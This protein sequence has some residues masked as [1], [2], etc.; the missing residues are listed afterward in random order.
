MGV[1]S[2]AAESDGVKV[3][4]D[5]SANT[6]TRHNLVPTVARGLWARTR[7]NGSPRGSGDPRHVQ[8][9]HQEEAH[10]W[11]FTEGKAP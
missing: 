8:M 3:P 6:L 2:R 4:G 7:R 9:D 10:R 11:A 5:R 1:E